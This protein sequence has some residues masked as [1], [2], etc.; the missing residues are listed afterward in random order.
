[1]V[2]C[3]KLE[4]VVAGCL[5]LIES[6]QKRRQQLL[7]LVLGSGYYEDEF[8]L[9]H[10]YSKIQES[11]IK[12]EQ[13]TVF[14]Q[15]S[16]EQ[17]EELGQPIQDQQ[18]L[19][20]E[21]LLPVSDGIV[22]EQ[23]VPVSDSCGL[24]QGP[25]GKQLELEIQSEAE[26]YDGEEGD[27]STH[28]QWD[29]GLTDS[30]FKFMQLDN[31]PVISLC[32]AAW[33]IH[34]LSCNK[35]QE[36]GQSISEIQVCELDKLLSSARRNFESELNSIWCDGLHAI[37][38]MEWP[39]ILKHIDQADVGGM[40][41]LV[42][43][44]VAAIICKYYSQRYSSLDSKSKEK[45]RHQMRTELVGYRTVQ[46]VQRYITIFQM[47]QL[48]VDG[49][50]MRPCPIED[51]VNLPR[52]RKRSEFNVMETSETVLSEKCLVA[53]REQEQLNVLF[54]MGGFPKEL[55]ER[56]NAGTDEEYLI[57]VVNRE[58][59]CL[60]LEQQM[61]HTGI[62][63]VKAHTPLLGSCAFQDETHPKWLHVKTRSRLCDML[64]ALDRPH[65]YEQDLNASLKD[66]FEGFWV[67]SFLRSANTSHVKD[68]LDLYT[69]KLRA[70]YV[71]V[72]DVLLN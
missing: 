34:E 23:S 11:R 58:P 41:D 48:L 43:E 3:E 5:G 9:D 4:A 26:S 12:E 20:S 36:F 21:D 38:C 2:Q 19:S 60:L 45:A 1:M 39:I 53:F 55:L 27:A 33:L 37:V 50:L 13:D 18:G 16:E 31:V 46:T 28:A 47:K 14:Q 59:V 24:V 8:Q 10:Q 61:A 71:N 70:L 69:G 44:F 35:Q 65:L 17:Q 62:A 15:Q 72:L 29:Y 64:R 40:N 67:L 66:L 6:K 22:Q 57:E 52:L 25:E 32:H 7:K 30:V 51:F 42:S 63:A 68:Q 56:V 54:S 49:N